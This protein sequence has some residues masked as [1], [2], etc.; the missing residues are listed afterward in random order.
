MADFTLIDLLNVLIDRKGSDLHI[1]VGE[2]PVI[3]VHGELHRLED[4]YP[5]LTA[6]DTKELMFS[7]LSPEQ[8]ATFERELELDTAFQIEGRGR[9][10]V[11]LMQQ[12]F[13]VGGVMRLIPEHIQTIDELGIPQVLK[14]ISLLPRGL[15]LVTGP[16][17]SG[18]STTLAACIDY[19]NNNRRSHIITIEDPVEFV[20]KDKLSYIEQRQLGQDT[21]SFAE[22]LKHVLRQAPDIILVG[23]MRDPETISLAITAA[24]TGH[25]VFATLHTN[26][27]AQTIDRM[28]DVFDLEQQEQIR[29]QL[30]T[31]LMAVVCQS[32]LPLKHGRGRIAAFEIMRC[33]PAIRALIREAKTEQMYTIIEASSNLGMVSLD[34]YLLELVKQDKVTYEEALNKTSNPVEFEQRAAREGL[35]PS[36]TGGIGNAEV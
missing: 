11:N 15:I 29:S 4:E 22:A 10:R 28:V 7:I 2:P 25:L 35:K 6:E 34:A 19:I 1:K 13:C 20:H 17:G 14:E 3:R 16:T 33:T 26:D 21:L 5:R 32:L 31:T 18:K 12:Q 36:P 23:E 30:G 24:E 27:A 8:R 9:F